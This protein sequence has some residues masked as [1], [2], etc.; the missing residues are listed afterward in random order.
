MRIFADLMRRDPR[1]EPVKA[2]PNWGL[3]LSQGSTI[4]VSPGKCQRVRLRTSTCQRCVEVCPD[5]AITLDP[6]PQIS[7]T[8]TE[9]GLCVRACPTEAFESELNRDEHL[10]D[11]AITHLDRCQGEGDRRTLSIR[12][13][14]ADSPI[15]GTVRVPCLGTVG[16][17]FFFGASLAGFDEVTLIRGSCARCRLTR[18]S[19]QVSSREQRGAVSRWVL[20][21]RGAEAYLEV[22]RAPRGEK[23]NL[24]AVHRRP[25]QEA[26]EICGLTPA[27]GLMRGSIKRA[28][29]LA[30]GA[31]LG[32][33]SITTV[34]RE[35]VA[36]APVGRREMFVGIADR[37]RTSAQAVSPGGEGSFRERVP[38]KTGPNRDDGAGGSPAR[39]FLRTLLR[40]ERREGACPVAFDSESPWARVTVDED[41]CTACG[42]CVSVCPTDAIEIK[43]EGENRVLLFRPSACTN[44]SLCREACI[45]GVID[46]EDEIRIADILQDQAEVIA[47][48]KPAWCA[49]CGDVIP[50]GMD[51]M[52]L[53]CERRQV[54]AAHLKG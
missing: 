15:T 31:G 6:G 29:V 20:D 44:C 52:C 2:R 1:R 23:T 13:G 11:Q 42:T 33:I 30:R 28:G 21:P 9:C 35:K 10:L 34:E 19:H 54:S 53:T 27:E 25:Q 14:R 43:E 48:I 22:R 38:R 16:E 12:C 8:C 36:R 49:I 47:T 37:V 5:D 46:Y 45:E 40:S 4:S 7:D 17:N 41:R 51:E 24:G 32:E 39:R 50:T 26:G 18:T 3:A